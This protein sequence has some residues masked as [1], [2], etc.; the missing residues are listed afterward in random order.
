M[1]GEPTTPRREFLGGVTTAV[2]LVGGRWRRTDDSTKTTVDDAVRRAIRDARSYLFDT[3]LDSGYTHW[4]TH[5]LHGEYGHLRNTLFF[6]LLLARI[7]RRPE[8]REN[9]VTYLLDHRTENG[10]W[11]DPATNFGAVLL[12]DQLLDGDY[13]DVVDDIRSEVRERDQRLTDNPGKSATVTNIFR[14][15]LLYAAL[16][17]DYSYS[18]LFPRNLP[19]QLGRALSLTDAFDGETIS[20]DRHLARHGFMGYQSAYYLIGSS[21]D[22]ANL[23]ERDQK[24]QRCLERVL[25][26]RQLTRGT[27]GASTSTVFG[28]FA[29][30]ERGYDPGDDRLRYPVDWI[31]DNR[32]TDEGRVEIWRLPVWDTGHIIDALLESGVSPEDGRVREA[33]RWLYRERNPQQ[34]ANPVGVKLDRSPAPF[35]RHSRAGWGWRKSAFTDWDDTALAVNV[36]SEFMQSSLKAEEQLLLDTQNSDGSW[37]TFVTDFDPFDD[38]T[39]EQMRE[40]MPDGLYRLFFGRVTAPDVTGGVLSAL[41]KLGHTVDDSEAVA[42]AVDYLADARANNGMW[43][44]VWAQGF[45][46]A[47][48]RVLRG[49][50]A[51]GVDPDRP[52]VQESVRALLER[53][54]EDG[55]WGEHSKYQPGSSTPLSVPYETAA[56]NPTQTGWVLKGLLSVG[57]SPDDDAIQRG[58]DFLLRTQQPDG[59]WPAD[60]VMYNYG[61]PLYSTAGTTQASAL[62]ALAMYANAG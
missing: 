33:A 11:G 59:S 6:S 41:G 22:G 61:G 10:G 31:A 53:Q 46:Y 37:S 18:E 15:R 16:S 23:T 25:L 40:N 17:E 56:S 44:G 5:V 51:V 29:L 35:R 50:R 13:R 1:N 4:D 24:L 32:V 62:K 38:A 49:L 26:S 8:T 57:V 3:A 12:F 47:S 21:S 2:P 14:V 30:L 34:V 19:I 45:T 52:L 36:L 48:G 54:N 7:G 20:A 60:R 42:D 28:S 39:E 9:C 55:G 27:W 58:V 43:L